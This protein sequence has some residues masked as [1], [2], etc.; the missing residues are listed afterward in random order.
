MIYKKVLPMKIIYNQSTL[1]GGREYNQDRSLVMMTQDAI[2]LVVADGMGGYE[3]GELAAQTVIEVL[4]HNFQEYATPKIEDIPFFLRESIRD[5][6]HRI[7][8]MANA[9]NY[10]AVP[11]S[12]VVVALIQDGKIYIAYVGDSRCY[13]F[14]R[15]MMLFHTRDHSMVRHWLEEGLLSKE[16]ALVHPKRSQLYNCLGVSND[17]TIELLAPLPLR[18]NACVLL[19]SDGLWSEV[20]HNELGLIFQSPVN[21][22]KNVTH[23]LRQAVNRAGRTADNTTSVALMCLP[24][25]TNLNSYEGFVDTAKIIFPTDAAQAILE[26]ELRARGRLKMMA[27]S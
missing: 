13:V 26:S 17:L 24:D 18:P 9:R 3:N 8:N 15:R 21:L 2:L 23:A 25:N 19:C 27:S 11:G 4:A 14:D 12:T 1:S 6:H 7:L 10:D 16:E 20:D 22:Q 5:S